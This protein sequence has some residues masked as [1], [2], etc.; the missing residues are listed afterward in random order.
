MKGEVMIGLR[1]INE[2]GGRRCV[3]PLGA[4][5]RGL[6][7]GA[8]GTFAM[9]ALLYVRY[10]RSDGKSGFLRWEFSFDVL[11]WDDAPAP[12]H[13]GKRLYEGL[14][15]RDLPDHRAALVNDV[16]HWGYGI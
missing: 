8:A 13:V 5:A 2:E 3:T 16:M 1:R 14:F 12:A 7:A 4:I 15:Q 10:R 9:D 11:G 6:V